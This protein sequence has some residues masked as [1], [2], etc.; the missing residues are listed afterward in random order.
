[1]DGKTQR[2]GENVNAG[3]EISETQGEHTGTRGVVMTK[4]LMANDANVQSYMIT[5]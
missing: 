4:T 2:S 3:K 1:M 5:T